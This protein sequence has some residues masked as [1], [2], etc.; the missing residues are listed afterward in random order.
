MVKR[1]RTILIIKGIRPG[2]PTGYFQEPYGDIL[3]GYPLVDLDDDNQLDCL[4]NLR[5]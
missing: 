1:E 2:M 4:W 5:N 3:A